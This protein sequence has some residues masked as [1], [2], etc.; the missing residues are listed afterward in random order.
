MAC[1]ETRA[2]VLLALLWEAHLVLGA[3][4]VGK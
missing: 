2:G 4:R 1:W 3:G